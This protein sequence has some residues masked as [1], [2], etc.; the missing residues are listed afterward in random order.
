MS[1]GSFSGTRDADVVPYLRLVSS[2]NGDINERMGNILILQSISSPGIMLKH[3]PEFKLMITSLCCASPIRWGTISTIILAFTNALAIQPTAISDCI[4]DLLDIC[5]TITQAYK[6]NP[7]ATAFRPNLL[8]LVKVIARGFTGP[9]HMTIEL[10]MALTRQ[11]S[12]GFVPSSSFIPLMVQ[13][14]NDIV[15]I[16]LQCDPEHYI[17]LVAPISSTRRSVKQFYTSIWGIVLGDMFDRPLALLALARHTESLLEMVASKDTT[18]LKTAAKY[19]LDG[20]KAS[21][22][23][24]TELVKLKRDMA[25]SLSEFVTGMLTKS[26]RRTG[27]HVR[28]ESISAASPPAHEEP[29]PQPTGIIHRQAADLLVESKLRNKVTKVEL[30]LSPEAGVVTWGV[31]GKPIGKG[32]ACHVSEITSVKTDTVGKS[33]APEH[34]LVLDLTS[35]TTIIFF[36]PT[37]PIAAQWV[38][39]IRGRMG[40]EVHAK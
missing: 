14:A 24:R 7:V 3:V 4:F 29:K 25:K 36:L 31:V 20:I 9:L 35:K 37:Q 26:A 19:L 6:M 21:P 34:R 8:P 1:L 2:D 12:L 5:Y 33:G 40:Q 39:L 32:E 17:A 28:T 18:P 15:S 23:Q 38:N 10:L 11:C 16:I 22:A 30:V 13:N 27:E